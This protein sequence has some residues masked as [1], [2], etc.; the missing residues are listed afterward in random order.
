MKEE[1]ITSKFSQGKI[2]DSQLINC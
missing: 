2:F 1:D